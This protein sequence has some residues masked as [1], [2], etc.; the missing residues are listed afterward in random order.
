MRSVAEFF[1]KSVGA[2]ITIES[3]CCSLRNVAIMYNHG[4]GV[5][6]ETKH[7]VFFYFVVVVKF[8]RDHEFGRIFSPAWTT[9]ALSLRS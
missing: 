4:A 6:G 5:L 2:M 7:R 1:G 9:V 3:C 8:W